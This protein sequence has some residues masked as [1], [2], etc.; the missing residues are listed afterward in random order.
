[1]SI[2]FILILTAIVVIALPFR[3][4]FSYKRGKLRP[5]PW[6][7]IL[8]NLLLIFFLLLTVFSMNIDFATLI[9]GMPDASI[10]LIALGISLIFMALDLTLVRVCDRESKRLLLE[11]LTVLTGNNKFQAATAAM[12]II[13]AVWEE[14]CFRGFPV[15]LSK[16]GYVNISLGLITSCIVFGFQHTRNGWTG[17]FQATLYG[18]IFFYIY[19]TTESLLATI[20]PHFIGNLFI[21]FYIQPNLKN[22]MDR[23]AGDFW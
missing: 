1:M 13:S 15:L 18:G 11:R 7:T 2:I 5:N 22:E 3:G 14:L 17:V 16:Q 19:L 23:V 20:I 21:F 9:G 10:F 12:I 4:Y 8:E 6:R